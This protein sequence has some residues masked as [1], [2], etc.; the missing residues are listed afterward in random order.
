MGQHGVHH[1]QQRPGHP[2]GPHGVAHHVAVLLHAPGPDVQRDDDAKDQSGNGIHRLV[3]VQEA[4]GHRSGGV[5]LTLRR[6]VAL[7]W[8]HQAADEG[9]HDEE[10]QD[11]THDLSQA[12][13][14]LLRPQ[15]HHQ[16]QG[17]KHQGVKDLQHP[18][19]G[20]RPHKGRHRH[21]KGGT[22]RSG[23]GQTGA[24][25][26]IGHNG[27]YPGKEGMDPVT[28]SIQAAGEGHRHHP[29]YGETH[30]AHRHA[31]HG[32]PGEV[33]RLGT[34]AGGK[35]QIA[36]AEKHGKQGKPQQQLDPL[37]QFLHSSS[38]RPRRVPLIPK[39]PPAA[40]TAP[41]APLLQQG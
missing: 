10:E 22:G 39:R 40:A 36:C 3:A 28:Q 33:P 6:A 18:D 11:G 24:D 41:P 32:Q 38:F 21:L 19:G 23:D 2:A 26:Q 14:E 30:G 5:Q 16:G 34:Y 15:R 31:R 25:G 27:E 8:V 4:P 35:D 29:Q 17:E 20:V 37:A 12:V 9:D 1:Q 7:Q 13:G